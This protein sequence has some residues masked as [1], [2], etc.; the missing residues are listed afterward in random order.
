LLGTT[1]AKVS[2]QV[3][4]RSVVEYR[5]GHK[6]MADTVSPLLTGVTVGLIVGDTVGPTVYERGDLYKLVSDDMFS[7]RKRSSVQHS[8][9]TCGKNCGVLCR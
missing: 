7:C 1:S 3:M 5:L 9:R 6:P 4:V 8:L 2:Q